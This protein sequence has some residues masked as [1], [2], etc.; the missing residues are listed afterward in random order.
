MWDDNADMISV[1]WQFLHL[2]LVLDTCWLS[3]QLSQQL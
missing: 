2:V 1:D 3:I